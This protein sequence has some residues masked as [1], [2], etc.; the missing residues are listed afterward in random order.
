MLL[1][2]P[3][4]GQPVHAARQAEDAE[5]LL[6]GDPVMT[7]LGR[8]QGRLL[9]RHLAR[10]GFRGRIW[11]SPY[12]RAAET[13]DLVA[14]ELGVTFEVRADLRD[15]VKDTTPRQALRGQPIAELRRAYPHLADGP[16]PFPWWTMAT[17]DRAELTQ[18][19]VR[20]V[21]PLLTGHE[22]LLL[23][24]H[25]ATVNQLTQVFS[26][27][28]GRGDLGDW[29]GAWN[30]QLTTFAVEP[31]TV[32]LVRLGDVSFLTPRQTTAN[33]GCLAD[34]LDAGTG[35]GPDGVP[36]DTVKKGNP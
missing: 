28:A 35:A 7:A 12:R 4:H 3:R 36:R 26:K 31:G 25:G 11:S 2:L 29:F 22:D 8:A 20:L 13:A 33:E 27:R 14:G 21:E 9:G 17:D 6:G 23:V 16:L 15:I 32:R 18:R 19:L 30:A 24:G 5:G 1:H 34:G 10:L